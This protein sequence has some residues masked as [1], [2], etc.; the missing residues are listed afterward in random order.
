MTTDKT[1]VE[2]LIDRLESAAPDAANGHILRES[3]AMLRSLL[4]E[5]HE[6][7]SYIRAMEAKCRLFEAAL[8]KAD[9]ERDALRAQLEDATRIMTHA[10]AER[11]A[12]KAGAS[13]FEFDDC[14][15]TRT[16]YGDRA[17]IKALLRWRKRQEEITNNALRAAK[18]RT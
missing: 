18:E 2:A 16:V 15:Q 9:R 3:A 17:S 1:A 8:D 11:D 10:V 5:R 12:L 7:Q 4:A 14:G 6:Q 13:Y